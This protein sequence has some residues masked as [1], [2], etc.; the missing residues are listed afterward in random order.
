M[1]FTS[2]HTAKGIARRLPPLP[3]YR[4]VRLLWESLNAGEKKLVILRMMA[5][6]RPDADDIEAQREYAKTVAEM[7][8]DL[9][10]VRGEGHADGE[11]RAYGAV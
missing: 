3:S 5:V 10:R 2:T 7:A 6:D 11:A 8:Y 9:L 1:S 4:T